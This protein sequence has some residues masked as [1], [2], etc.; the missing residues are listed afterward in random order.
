MRITFCKI[1]L[2]SVDYILI[3]DSITLCQS[4]SWDYL[5]CNI[6]KKKIF[7]VQMKSI[8]KSRKKSI[9][10]NSIV[11]RFCEEG[12]WSGACR[13]CQYKA[14]CFTREGVRVQQ[15]PGGAGPLLFSNGCVGIRSGTF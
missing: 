2:L 11:V 13:C 7:S 6:K 1:E 15:S 5:L 10:K 9:F 4:S 12:L 8:F 3:D 14:P